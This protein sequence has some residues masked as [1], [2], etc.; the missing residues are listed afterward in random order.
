M[1]PYP[2]QSRS[3]RHTPRGLSIARVTPIVV[4]LLPRKRE[5]G[6]SVGAYAEAVLSHSGYKL[7]E[8]QKVLF[9]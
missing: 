4:L 9:Y 2:L 7:T 6:L 8:G 1:A 5:D 3:T